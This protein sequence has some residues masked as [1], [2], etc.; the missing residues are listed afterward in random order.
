MLK[1]L[2]VGLGG[3]GTDICKQVAERINWEFGDLN[4]VGFVKFL[5]IDTS[6]DVVHN[7]D[8]DNNND[9]VHLTID[10][11]TLENMRKNMSSFKSIELDD[12]I[13][14]DVLNIMNLI[15]TGTTGVRM[16]G[17]L[18]FLYSV[19]YNSVIS[20]I[21]QKLKDLS[22]LTV[23]Q[24]RTTFGEG[25]ESI[26]FIDKIRIYVIA[27]SCGGT[28]S[29]TFI[30]L[31]YLFQDLK[32]VFSNI[33]VEGILTLPSPTEADD[34]QKINAYSI[35]TELNHFSTNNN[36]YTVKYEGNPKQTEIYGTPYD[37]SYI[38]S[39]DRT[40]GGI[41]DFRQLNYTI[42]QY[43][44]ANTFFDIGNERDGRI[45]DIT[46]YF[47]E[48]DKLGYTQRFM[49][50]GISLI[51][52]PNEKVI[53]GCTYKLL[54]RT[55][56]EWIKDQSSKVKVDEI[57][58]TLG[59][60]CENL[61]KKL[62]IDD[63]NKGLGERIDGL[64][65]DLKKDYIDS[66]DI[67]DL[68]NK[69]D[70]GFEPVEDIVEGTFPKGI[71][72]RVIKNNF[73]NVLSNYKERLNKHIKDSLF[74]L[75]KGPTY[76]KK[77]LED[78]DGKLTS[79]IN[80]NNASLSKDE[81]EDAVDALNYTDDFLLSIFF[82]KRMVE[83]E[84]LDDFIGSAKVYYRDKLKNASLPH[85]AECCKELQR[86][87]NMLLKRIKNLQTYLDSAK[88]NFNILWT[89]EDK[90]ININGILLFNP[91]SKDK[92][93]VV[94][95]KSTINQR[96]K[97]SID[98][99]FRAEDDPE[100]KLIEEVI[101]NLEDITKRDNRD[102]IF[103]EPIRGESFYDSIEKLR[104]KDKYKMIDIAKRYFM[105]GT[106]NVIE[107]FDFTKEENKKKLEECAEDLSYI[108][109]YLHEGDPDYANNERKQRRWAFFKDAHK[110]IQAETPLAR[111]KNIIVNKRGITPANL[112]DPYTVIFC[113]DRGA[114][115]L[116][117]IRGLG[118]WKNLYDNVIGKPGQPFPFTRKDVTFLAPHGFAIKDFHEAEELYLVGIAI[119]I[120]K[121]Q[122]SSED[123]I[124]FI[125]PG[126]RAP[127]KF[128][129]DIRKAT[130]IVY[131]D[132]NIRAILKSSI[133]R[134]LKERG[135]EIFIQKLFG[136]F[137]N[138]FKTLGLE[139]P[140]TKNDDESWKQINRVFTRHVNRQPVLLT[141]YVKAYPP[142]FDLE[143]LKHKED[144]AI[145]G[146]Y[147]YPE[148]GYYCDEC[149]YHYGA[150]QSD[151]LAICPVSSCKKVNYS[152]EHN[153]ISESRDEISEFSQ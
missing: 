38:L 130:N 66:G 65:E 150:K 18:A 34:R 35:L 28:G 70:E 19:N 48:P 61:H 79:L 99:K 153:I 145:D 93:D 92:N 64:I 137:K 31:G 45:N 27:T 91:G 6:R 37:R 115:P 131:N 103:L 106:D 63:K 52:Y 139:I 88:N 114:F 26:D 133:T 101:S 56:E 59:L 20:I 29:G 110:D 94:S 151:V 43:I 95:D 96:Y 102:E 9:F 100:I 122:I 127:I 148:T 111:F 134:W 118:E 13:D 8:L 119:D 81:I 12:W 84:C 75:N 62:T 69:L 42:A 11:N 104:D 144:E 146:K 22:S 124:C 77:F 90:P 107:M 141:A 4:K 58:K 86:W 67:R 85:E 15:E 135:E 44:Y 46:G 136:D 138:R 143:F 97:M 24:A 128:E 57:L 39:T 129:P 54:T 126:D 40:K 21:K 2:I 72:D 32:K 47:I 123:K 41:N 7:T 140:N 113:H 80:R 112:K 105:G 55:L 82:L 3:T 71:I 10:H 16:L 132:P 5:S 121:K 116:R 125:L 14:I 142:D 74:N 33:T 147:Y 73:K 60:D 109:L 98:K 83:D 50:F 78:L 30:D 25:S 87:S 23:P 76:C 117:I 53:K 108:F 51:Q 36:E 149:N 89:E 1:S 49:T 17:R 152:S 68:R 120:I